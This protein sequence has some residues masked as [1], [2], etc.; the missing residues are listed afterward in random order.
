LKEKKFSYLDVAAII[1]LGAILSAVVQQY[2]FSAPRLTEL[3]E[4]QEEL[5]TLYAYF[6]T[7]LEDCGGEPC[8]EK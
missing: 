4:C 3:K 5:A 6:D 7:T 1:F 8:P 2:F